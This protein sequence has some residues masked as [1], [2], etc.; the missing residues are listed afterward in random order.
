MDA[1]CPPL[2]RA[3]KARP[4]IR[5]VQSLGYKCRPGLMEC[6]SRV[7]RYKGYRVC[8]VA[9]GEAPSICPAR[10]FVRFVPSARCPMSILPPSHRGM[11]CTYIRRLQRLGTIEVQYG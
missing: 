6:C 1:A 10:I 2:F 5:L 7:D 8:A 9:P 3:D 4:T 11:G